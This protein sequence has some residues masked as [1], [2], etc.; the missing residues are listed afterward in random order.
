MQKK[1]NSGSGLF[2][3]VAGVAAGAAA[4]FL[5]KKENRDMVK[6]EVR[7]DVKKVK[8]VAAEAKKDPK[9]FAKKVET[10][11]KKIAGKVASN[12]KKL[13]KKAMAAEKSV[14]KKVKSPVMKS[15]G[16]KAKR[17]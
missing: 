6:K 15:V 10:K 2:A 12:A 3:L 17:K 14:M 13:E 7:K 5:S 4:V 1:S 16:K 9:K 11:S 8:A